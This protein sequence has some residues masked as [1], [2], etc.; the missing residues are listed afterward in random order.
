MS[1]KEHKEELNVLQEFM[2]KKRILFYKRE[3]ALGKRDFNE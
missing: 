1:Y 3:E 2:I